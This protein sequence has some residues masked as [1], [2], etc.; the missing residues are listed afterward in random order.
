MALNTSGVLESCSVTQGGVYDITE[1]GGSGGMV[2]GG[3]YADGAEIAAQFSLSAG[4]TFEVVTGA[5]GVSSGLSSSG[6]GGTFFVLDSGGTL[7]PYLVAGGGGGGSL[8]P[9][10]YGQGGQVSGNPSL[11]SG[12]GG[13]GYY[14][15]SGGGY[16]TSGGNGID[17]SLGG[18][19][20]V[21]QPVGST[22]AGSGGEALY[23]SGVYAGGGGGGYDGGD[24]AN[25]N[26]G[27]AGNGGTNYYDPNLAT[28]VTQ[29]AGASDTTSVTVGQID[30]TLVSPSSVPEP[31]AILLSATFL[32][33]LAFVRYRVKV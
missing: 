12:D 5:T 2:N 24:G 22:Y 29:A 16:L 27:Y 28:N 26:N 25:A 33:L 1:Y 30:F 21:G 3:L 7:T 23:V 13:T 31:P 17:S 19:S 15:G 4:Q 32:G 10:Y 9:A 18:G 11:E 6:G 8:Q 20:F 14:A